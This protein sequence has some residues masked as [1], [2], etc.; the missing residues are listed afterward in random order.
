MG[1]QCDTQDSCQ[2]KS[3]EKGSGISVPM[4][5]TNPSNELICPD[6]TYGS[7][8][9]EGFPRGRQN[10][11]YILGRFQKPQRLAVRDLA[12]NIPSV[13]GILSQNSMVGIENAITV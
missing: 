3:R 6:S 9:V 7:K 13:Y 12:D 4:K 11:I 5:S 2:G 1:A 8:V 10:I